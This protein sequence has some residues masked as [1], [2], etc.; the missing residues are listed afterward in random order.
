MVSGTHRVALLASMTHLV[1]GD[2]R[3]SAYEAPD[4]CSDVLWVREIH[5]VPSS[6]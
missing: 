1:E 3:P 6:Y 4:R 2:R 5:I